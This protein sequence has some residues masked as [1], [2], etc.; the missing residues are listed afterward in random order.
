MRLLRITSLINEDILLRHLQVPIGNDLHM[1]RLLSHSI[2][3]QYWNYSDELGLMHILMA[4]S[5]RIA[6]IKMQVED[7]QVI[8]ASI[9]EIP[10]CPIPEQLN[11]IHKIKKAMI[12][13]R[14]VI[15]ELYLMLSNTCRFLR[16]MYSLSDEQRYISLHGDGRHG[17]LLRSVFI[18][19]SSKMKMSHLIDMMELTVL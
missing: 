16:S 17:G 13:H 5:E 6:K 3:G 12:S 2:V 1:Q 14:I 10:G 4:H 11:T 9:K 7:V 15:M 8:S 18:A 19:L